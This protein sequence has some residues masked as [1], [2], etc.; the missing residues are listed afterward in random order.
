MTGKAKE[1][2]SVE[3]YVAA[4]T[5]P[6]RATLEALRLLVKSTL[7]E[8]T[9]GMKWGAPVYRGP[10]GQPLIYLYGGK[11]HVNLGFL[12]GAELDDPD[13]LLEGSGKP[14]RTIRVQ[15]SQEIPKKEIRKLL[16]QSARLHAAGG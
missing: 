10:D 2:Q 1:S 9:E 16:R 6:V 8:L 15:S 12:R 14:S 4:R 7:P 13:K 5:A 3:D 11:G